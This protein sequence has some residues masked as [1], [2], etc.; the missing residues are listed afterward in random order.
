M[1]SSMSYSSPAHSQLLDL[2]AGVNPVD[3]AGN[4]QVYGG[5]PGSP[6][7]EHTQWI[8]IQ[9]SDNSIRYSPLFTLLVPLGFFCSF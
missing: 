2:T 1:P 3:N 8:I 6:T 5:V 9:N 4:A 7:D